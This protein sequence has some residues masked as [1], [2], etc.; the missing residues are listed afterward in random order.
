MCYALVAIPAQTRLQEE[1][2]EEVRGRVFGVL[3][4]L[5]SVA[6][7]VPIIIIAPISDLV[8]TTVVIVAVGAL[9]SLVGAVSIL[10]RPRPPGKAPTAGG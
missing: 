1:L 7:L 4:S 3:F 8:G 10:S 5:I 6:S 2:P 9:V